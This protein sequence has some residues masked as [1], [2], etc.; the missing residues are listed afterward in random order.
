MPDQR[1]RIAIVTGASGG[2]GLR[3]AEVLAGRGALVIVTSRDPG[4]GA[5]ALHRVRRAASA[6]EPQ[7]VALD[8]ADLASVR[9]AAADIRA[10]TD[11][12]IDLLLNNAGI[13]APPLGYS[14]DGFELQWATNVLGPTALAWLLLP[15]LESTPGSR[16]VFV[17]SDRSRS[18]TLDEQRMRADLRG[19]GYR[20]FDY[21]GRTKLADLLLA[22]QLDRHFRGRG[23]DTRALAAHPGFTATGIVGSGFAALPGFAHRIATAA[24]SVLG[25]PVERGVLPILFAATA[26]DARGGEYYGPTG[27]LELRGRV[28]PATRGVASTEGELGA[29]V[30][31]VVSEVTGIRAPS[32]S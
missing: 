18:A 28:G 27:I 9:A 32:G 24:T 14:V 8:V 21:Y 12:H 13:M 25:Q 22:T 20:G 2:L 17:S 7:L 6:A 5:A 30:A 1:G 19:E 23:I 3:A 10:R 31:R 15:S 11:G 16:V 26:A 4:R 29:M